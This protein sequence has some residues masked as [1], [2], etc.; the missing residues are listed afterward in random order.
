MAK[1]R[2]V[3]KTANSA[4]EVLVKYLNAI[5]DRPELNQSILVRE[6]QQELDQ[7]S[8]DFDDSV[9]LVILYTRLEDAIAALWSS[10]ESARVRQCACGCGKWFLARTQKHR[11]YGA[12]RKR[13]WEL[14]MTEEQ[15]KGRR[16]RMQ[17]FMQ[18]YYDR[19]FKA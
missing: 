12:H 19:N 8:I 18:S 16:V 10:T 1:N 3:S 5:V 6:L 14:A 15:K 17:R 2:Q 4:G 9:K 7:G 13:T 11:H